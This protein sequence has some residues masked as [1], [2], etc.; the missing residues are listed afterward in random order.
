MPVLKRVPQRLPATR[1]R[2]ARR[3]PAQ[4]CP[5]QLLLVAQ[6]VQRF[7]AGGLRRRAPSLT[8][9]RVLRRM[10]GQTCPERALRGRW[11]GWEQGQVQAPVRRQAPVR[12]RRFPTLR[13]PA[14]RTPAITE[15]AGRRRQP[16]SYVPC[17]LGWSSSA[18]HSL[19][20]Y[21]PYI[22]VRSAEVGAECSAGVSSAAAQSQNGC[23]AWPRVLGEDAVED[24]G[25]NADTPGASQAPGACE[26]RKGRQVRLRPRPSPQLRGH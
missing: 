21:V 16:P 24:Q 14:C 17:L 12:Q 11:P 9:H 10:I 4:H 23:A 25:G 3:C 13:A 18:P 1:L 19:L 7:L 15:A 26:G 8:Q 5:A 20:R 2:P 6:G 22:N